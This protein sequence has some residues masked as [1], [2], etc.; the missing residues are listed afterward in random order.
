MS[1]GL[2]KIYNKMYLTQARIKYLK[3]SI[4]VR[5]EYKRQNTETFVRSNLDSKE[6]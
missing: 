3:K 6:M 2:R 5:I 4:I 1:K